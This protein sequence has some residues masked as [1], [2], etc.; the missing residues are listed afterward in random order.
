MKLA[1]LFKEEILKYLKVD[2]S[3]LNRS[4]IIFFIFMSH[5]NPELRKRAMRH[6]KNLDIYPQLL[7]DIKKYF[8]LN[9]STIGRLQE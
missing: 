9:G 5:N 4:V 7:I 6:F 1:E 8:N 2:I 3:E